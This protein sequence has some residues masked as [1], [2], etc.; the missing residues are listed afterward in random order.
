MPG[1]RSYT[2]AVETWTRRSTPASRAAR[3]TTGVPSTETRCWVSRSAPIGWT[4]VTT[5]LAPS[6]TVAAK[7]A[8]SN[9]PTH[10]ST[11]A[12]RGTAPAR[13]TTPRTVAPRSTSAAQVRDPTRPLA[14]VTTTTG[15][16]VPLDPLT[17]LPWHGS[18]HRLDGARH[19]GH[20]GAGTVT[21]ADG[22]RMI[23][24]V[25]GFHDGNRS[26]QDRFDTRALADRIDELL[27]AETISEGD[28]AFIE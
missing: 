13:R 18:P 10:S 19:E 8:S 17:R 4:V 24:G 14:P 9:S 21:A 12:I 7:S 5:A 15:D 22:G 23:P 25:S 6:T 16:D 28:R 26:L 20:T 2:P 1:D 27:V 3:A 11:P